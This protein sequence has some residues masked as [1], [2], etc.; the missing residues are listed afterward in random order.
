MNSLVPK[1][2]LCALAVL[3]TLR[4]E[5]QPDLACFPSTSPVSSSCSLEPE[6]W[7]RLTLYYKR[8]YYFP[9][10]LKMACIQVSF[11]S[12]LAH[13]QSPSSLS[14]PV[15][16][17]LFAGVST[18]CLSSLVRTSSVL[19]HMPPLNSTPNLHPNSC[20]ISRNKVV[21]LGSLYQLSKPTALILQSSQVTRDD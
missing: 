18:S 7:P 1:F 16:W 10:G 12:S 17:Q 21:Q 20:T 6:L 15:Q 3:Q 4:T 2:Q 11:P 19:S 13:Q 9:E 14:G 5:A 8:L